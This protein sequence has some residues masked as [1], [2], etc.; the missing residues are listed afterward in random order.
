MP[1]QPSHFWIPAARARI[2]PV[3]VQARG[4]SYIR[5]DLASHSTSLRTAFVRSM[6][7]FVDKHDLDLATELI[8]E[9]S[10]TADRPISKERQHLRNLGF[11]IISL[12]PDA[13]NVTNLNSTHRSAAVNQKNRPVRR[14]S[15]ISGKGISLQSTALLRWQSRESSTRRS[16]L[17]LRNQRP[18]AS[19]L[20]IHPCRQR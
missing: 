2:E 8:V 1:E 13:P 11:E 14:D 4:D 17:S 7:L 9:I 12:S 16:R 10:T 15:G 20:F 19:S 6:E 18:L 5:E 3:I